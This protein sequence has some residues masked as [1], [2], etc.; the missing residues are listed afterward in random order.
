MFLF[1]VPDGVCMDQDRGEWSFEHGSKP[2][3][4]VKVMKSIDSLQRLPASDILIDMYKYAPERTE[5]A[6]YKERV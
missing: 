4:S 2:A 3:R 5:D 6:G 1:V